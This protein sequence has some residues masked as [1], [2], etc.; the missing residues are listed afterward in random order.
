MTFFIIKSNK[1]RQIYRNISPSSPHT[2]LYKRK[3]NAESKK[4]QQKA[5]ILKKTTRFCPSRSY[6]FSVGPVTQL[7]RPNSA[8]PVMVMLYSIYTVQCTKCQGSQ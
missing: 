6:Y 1:Q 8:F 4:G 5:Q 7:A 3:C 2:T